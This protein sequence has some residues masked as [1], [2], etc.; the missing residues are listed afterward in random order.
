[1]Y[2]QKP[3]GVQLELL[4]VVHAF[5]RPKITWYKDGERMEKKGDGEEIGASTGT[6]LWVPNLHLTGLLYS[7]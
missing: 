7:L 3:T 2:V 6:M 1:M 5:P 4:C